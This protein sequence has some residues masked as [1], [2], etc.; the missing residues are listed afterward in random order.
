MVFS[1][2]RTKLNVWVSSHVAPPRREHSDEPRRLLLIHAHPRADS[3]SHALADAVEN[4]AR[5]GGH[6][7]RRF[8]L[9]D[10]A[11]TKKE[12]LG[13]S[14]QPCLT[15][16]EITAY[17]KTEQGLS[18]FAPDV[19]KALTDLHWCDSLVFVYP[20]WWS[21]MPAMLKG[22][23]DRV[24]MPG[25][26]GAFD[27]P[28]RSEL[29]SSTPDAQPEDFSDRRTTSAPDG[30]RVNPRSGLVPRLTNVKRMAGVSTYGAPRHLVF[31]G[32]DDG[33]NTLASA[34]RQNFAPDC[35]CL[36]MGF[37]SMEHREGTDRDGFVSLVKKTFRDDF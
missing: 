10:Y 30:N 12:P 4:G 14:F 25:P 18:R 13:V 1:F 35:T 32:G 21:N 36:W 19:Q 37:Y 31:L 28:P 24:M 23:L 22:Y 17:G 34:V 9:Y 2:I 16:D 7:V 26:E 20:T 3:Y 33:R 29:A 15:A 8:A 6:E 27:M 11:G 5:E